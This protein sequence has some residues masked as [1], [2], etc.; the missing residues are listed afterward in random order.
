LPRPAP[1][2]RRR[3]AP[4]TRRLVGGL[5]T[6]ALTLTVGFAVRPGD[7]AV[8]SPPSPGRFTGYAFDACTAPADAAMDAWLASPF[9]AV[10]IY[11]GGINRGCAQPN[12]TATWVA[13]QQSKGWKMIPIYVGLQAPCRVTGRPKIDPAQAAAQGTSQADDAATQAAATGLGRGSVLIFD[14]EAYPVPDAACT[15]AVQTFMSAWSD[16][17]HKLG[18]YSGFYSSMTSGVADMVA[19]YDNPGFVRPDFIDFARWD[20]V[21]TLQDPAIPA[22]YWSDHRRMKQYSGDHEEVW[23]GVAITVD[24]NY[25]DFAPVPTTPF[26]DSTGDG[27]SDLLARDNTNRNLYLYPGNGSKLL[28]RIQIGKGWGSMT[29]ILRLGDFDRRG[30]ED[31]LGRHSDGNLYLYPGAGQG[32]T[33]GRIIGTHWT[34]MR[35]LT[36]IGDLTGD[37]WR[38]LLAV[39]KSTGQL[40]LYPGKGTGFYS[41]LILGTGWNAYDELAGAGDYNHDG[42]PDLVA[43]MIATGELYLLTGRPSGFNPPVLISGGWGDRRDLVAVGDFD[44]DGSPDF[45]AVNKVT[46]RL[47]LYPGSPETTVGAPYNVSRGWGALS[48]LA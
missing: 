37:G 16:R 42:R 48:P 7:A 13:R 2:H 29:A 1:R 6:I 47:D 34:G 15:A 12:L 5:A 22:D 40:Y 19:A 8:T 21:A 45:F 24:S 46:L 4:R 28:S 32:L 9:R 36:G 33:S 38:D 23:G 14:M 11:F 43:R 17:L 41:P 27:W 10:G 44:R 35:E 31:V 39:R 18:Y 25:V 3:L 30:S 20:G 26:A